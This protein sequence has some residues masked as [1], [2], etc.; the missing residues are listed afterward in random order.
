MKLNLDPFSYETLKILFVGMM[1]F[2]LKDIYLDGVHPMMMIVIKSALILGMFFFWSMIA[3]VGQEEWNWIKS[4][5][6]KSGP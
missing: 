1:I 2:T 4:K 6:K 3:N 5:L